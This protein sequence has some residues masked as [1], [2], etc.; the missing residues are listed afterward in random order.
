MKV[1][2]CRDLGD[3]QEFLHMCITWKDGKIYLDQVAYLK[4]VLQCFDIYNMHEVPTLLL[5]GYQPLPN[6]S[7]ANPALHSQF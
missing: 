5:E 7:P 4:K 1:W 2:E 6:K 3:A